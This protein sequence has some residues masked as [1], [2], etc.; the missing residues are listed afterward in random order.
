MLKTYDPPEDS[1]ADPLLYDAHLPL[2]STFHPMGYAV[3]ICS[4]SADVLAAAAKL[5][6]RYPALSDAEPIRIR[7]IAGTTQSSASR[8]PKPPRGEG[9]LFSITHGVDDFAL[10]DLSAGFAFASLSQYTVSNP[11]YFC[12]HFLEPL[13]YAMLAAQHFVLLH[14][15]CISRNQSA[16]VLCGDSG[17]GKTC[18]AYACA[19]R[20]WEFVSGDAVHVVRGSADRMLIGRPYEIRFRESA[21]ALFPELKFLRPGFRANGKIDLEIDTSELDIPTALQSFARHIVFIEQASETRMEKFPLESAM[22]KLEETICYGD[23]QTRLQQWDTL[24]HFAGM[25]IWRLCYS[26]L[27]KAEHTLKRLLDEELKC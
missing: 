21:R 11:S 6:N 24:R 19:K 2:K 25:P 13:V 16:V 12:Y 9:H 20:G 14:A 3:E 5:W 15:S 8:D 10:A 27:D 23:E 7:V 26:D 4:N 18:L 17:A 1:C 22:W